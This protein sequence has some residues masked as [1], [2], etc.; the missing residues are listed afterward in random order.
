MADQ[1]KSRKHGRAKEACKAYR[2]NEQRAFNKALRMFRVLRRNPTCTSS[3][4]CLKRLPEG[5]KRKARRV[6]EERC[7]VGATTMPGGRPVARRF[8]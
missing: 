2:M 1:K 7:A 3:G 6:Y 4:D 5:I 8:Q